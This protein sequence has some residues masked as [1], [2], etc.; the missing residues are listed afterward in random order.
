VRPVAYL[1]V[2]SL[3]IALIGCARWPEGSDG[4]NLPERLLDIVV[5]FAD[6]IDP[7]AFYFICFDTDGDTDTGPLPISRGPFWG[8]GWGTGTITAY[9]EY[10]SAGYRVYRSLMLSSLVDPA[11]GITAVTG[12]P[13][14]SIAGDHRVTIDRVTLGDITLTGTGP[15]ASATNAGDQNAGTLTIGTDTTGKTVP[16]SVAFTPASDGGRPVT[17]AE[18]QAIDTLNVGGVVLTAA[19]LNAFGMTL[20]LG[21]AQAGTQTVT[22][23]PTTADV[24]DRFQ[25]YF[26]LNDTTQQG[27]LYANDRSQGP[28]PVIPGVTFTT[29]ALTAGPIVEIVTQYD[30]TPDDL[31]PPFDSDLPAVGERTLH[32]VIDLAQI[33]DPTEPFQFNVIS[34]DLLPLSPEITLDKSYDGLGPD[35][36]T[37]VT[38]PL[39]TN[40]T[41]TNSEAVLPEGPND[42]HIGALS[43]PD[44]QPGVIDIDDWTVQVRLLSTGG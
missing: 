16:S 22:I 25:S 6:A 17:A 41:L 2:T 8:N 42:V 20:Q 14:L 31:G 15:I 39:D 13:T 30:P 29:A 23:A 10:S 4:G 40:R 11:G 19:S 35:G 33:G 28:T 27:T 34:T 12:N 36:T 9:V 18:Q 1:L 32:V 5:E 26:G 21:S 38:I 7:T 37:Y 43:D 44:F 24:T 3:A